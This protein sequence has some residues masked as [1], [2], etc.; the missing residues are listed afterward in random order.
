MSVGHGLFEPQAAR[1]VQGFVDVGETA[2]DLVC[3]LDGFFSFDKVVERGY[4]FGK[5]NDV[6]PVVINKA[7]VAL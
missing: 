1:I 3:D 6:I 4:L 5:P 7:N 2:H